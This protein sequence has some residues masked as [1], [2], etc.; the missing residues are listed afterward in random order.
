MTGFRFGT[1]GESE[2]SAFHRVMRPQGVA[3]AI[4]NMAA[5]VRMNSDGSFAHVRI[6]CGP[7]GP[8]PFRANNTEEYLV[9]KKWDESILSSASEIL[10]SEVSLRTSAHR[11]TKDYR[12]HLLPILLNEVM[13][14]AVERAS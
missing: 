4:L 6:S 5:W 11:A 7:A 3:I 14:K 9:G 8:K 2:A 13:N 1:R 10:S 12:H